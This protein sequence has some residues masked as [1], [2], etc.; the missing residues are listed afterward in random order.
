MDD[1]ELFRPLHCEPLFPHG[2][3][4]LE[5]EA[6]GD[7]VLGDCV[8]V[9]VVDH[10]R[11]DTALDA[12]EPPERLVFRHIATAAGFHGDRAATAHAAAHR[13]HHTIAYQGVV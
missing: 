6:G 5:V 4:R 1:Q 3:P 10:A 11:T 13:H 7:P 2:F 9:A 12:L 8:Y